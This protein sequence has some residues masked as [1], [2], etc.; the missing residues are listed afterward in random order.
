MTNSLSRME[1]PAVGKVLTQIMHSINR[2][3]NLV[4][5]VDNLPNFIILVNCDICGKWF[6]R[7]EWKHHKQDCQHKNRSSFTKPP[8][9]PSLEFT[10]SMKDSLREAA[11][12]LS[13][14]H[15]SSPL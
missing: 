6:C 11:L 4:K 2:N 14:S 5:F 7:R 8:D 10:E 13:S 9:P 1:S 3:A 15:V 12:S